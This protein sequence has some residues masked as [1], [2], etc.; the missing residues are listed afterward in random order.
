MVARYIVRLVLVS[1]AGFMQVSEIFA[2]AMTPTKSKSSRGFETAIATKR[3]DLGK[4][5]Q[6]PD[7]EAYLQCHY[8]SRVI[9]KVIDR[10]QKGADQISFINTLDSKTELPCRVE[11]EADEFVIPSE[12]SDGWKGYFMGV[13]NELVL[14]RAADSSNGAIGFTVFDSSTRKKVFEDRAENAV[15]VVKKNKKLEVLTYRRVYVASCSIPDVMGVCEKEVR[16]A[17]G[18][19]EK[20]GAKCEQGYQKSID[21]DAA[22]RCAEDKSKECLSREG[23][24]L[25]NTWKVPSV[26]SYPVEV[27]L[28]DFE[29]TLARGKANCWPGE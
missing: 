4:S 19:S 11:T 9:V 8:F 26:I 15:S 1:L 10:G 13:K 23:N 29:L 6:R 24:A 16:K 27:S 17:T 28:G 7:F 14:L 3:V 2:A 21:R 20:L 5:E 12:G 18:L 25:A 22:A